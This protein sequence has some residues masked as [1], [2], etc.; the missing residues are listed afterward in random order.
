MLF[1][2]WLSSLRLSDVGIPDYD[3]NQYFK[4]RTTVLTTNSVMTRI[5]ALP[6]GECEL[7]ILCRGLG[8][9]SIKYNPKDKESLE[10]ATKRF[11]SHVS[12][13]SSEN[14]QGG[15]AGMSV[16]K[17]GELTHVKEL[18]PEAKGHVIVAPIAGG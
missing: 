7:F 18:D 6:D 16:G 11:R 12:A 10:R 9:D 4:E 17:T 1:P 15:L 5:E 8:D 14:P 2:S 3:W 13:R